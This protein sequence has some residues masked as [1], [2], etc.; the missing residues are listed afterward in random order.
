MAHDPW[1][2]GIALSGGTL[3]AAAH[4]GVLSAL[5]QL[6]VRPDAIAGTSAGSLVGTLYAYG[7]S[8]ED[9]ERLVRSFPGWRLMDYGFP[10]AQS[11][12]ALAANRLGIRA[13]REPLP[14][15]LLRGVRFQAYIERLLKHRRPQIPIFVLAADLIS[16]RPVVFTPNHVR[17]DAVEHT[18]AMARAVAGSCALP[19]VFPPVEHGPYL[20]VDGAM[21]H[22]VPVSVLRQ[23]GCRR[24]LA[25]NLYRLPNPFHPKTLIDVFLRAFDI[26]LRESIDNDLD[27]PSVFLLEPDLS[28]VKGHPFE[29]LPAYIQ[30]GRACAQDHADAVLSFVRS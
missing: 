14:P 18:D 5:E 29:R 20:L 9:L 6:G 13:K 8:C 10:V 16:G 26:L 17:L 2:L 12:V 7:Y 25:V 1:N 28:G 11:L 21:R 30:A 19:G 4:I 15:G 27:A 23:M 22:Y 24:I 3:K